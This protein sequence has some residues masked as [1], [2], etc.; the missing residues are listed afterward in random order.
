MSDMT[1]TLET[2]R[3]YLKPLDLAD[4]EALQR[5]FPQW[6][7]VKFL[8][9]RIPWPYPAGE[10]KRFLS[11]VALPAI[12]RGEEWQWSLRPKTAPSSLIGI[13][14]LMNNADENRGFWLAPDWQGQGLMTEAC[15][16]A[17]GYWFNVLRKPVLRAP[18]AV[19]NTPSRRI[20]ARSGMRVIRVEERDYV[21]GRFKTEIWEITAEEWRAAVNH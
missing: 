8:T 2:E 14:H 13:M 18:K 10:A 11:E 6:E 17:T 19:V 12:A 20:S 16:V 9:A 15:G 5:I 4:A 1:P 3:L 21:A 7:I